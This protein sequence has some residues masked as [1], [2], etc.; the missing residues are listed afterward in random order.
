MYTF[1]MVIVTIIWG[2]TFFIIKD[3]V[4]TVNEYFIVFVRSGL[5]FLAMAIIQLIRKPSGF[6]NRKAML[7]GTIL[8][9]MLAITYATQT[10]G[11]KY[12]ST[13]HS[14]FITSSAVILVP[15]ILWVFFKTKLFRIDI[16]AVMVVFAGLFLLT[17]DIDTA[18]NTGDLIT[19]ITALACAFHIVL[20]GRYVK[21]GEALSIVTF[22]FLGAT[23]ASGAAW[24]V[25]GGQ[26]GV[27]SGGAWISMVY[28]GLIG[29]LVTYFITVWVQQYVSSLRVA[30]I[31]SLEPVFAT[32]FGYFILTETLDFRESAGAL[33]VLG[34]VV[35]HSVLKQRMNKVT[36]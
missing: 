27:V 9:V 36:R 21:G 20:A 18:V 25:S 8:G 30:I 4:A 22:Q 5:A 7:H 17:Y 23:L 12:T 29:T 33:F 14:A 19:I 35:L 16:M 28:L 11:L 6:L 15:L 32:I 24:L 10:I 13:G 31:F 26:T 2:S 3:T 1:W 34:G